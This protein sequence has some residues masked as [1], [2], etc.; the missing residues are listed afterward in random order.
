[1]STAVQKEEGV[2]VHVFFRCVQLKWFQWFLLHHE[3]VF[4]CVG[5]TLLPKGQGGVFFPLWLNPP[6]PA[7]P[8]SGGS[9]TAHLLCVCFSETSDNKASVN[10]HLAAVTALSLVLCDF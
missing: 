10:Q 1:M 2:F 6:F 8:A 3:K 4:V 7:P 5:S 9:Q